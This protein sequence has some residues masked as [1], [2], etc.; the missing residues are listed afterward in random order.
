MCSRLKIRITYSAAQTVITAWAKTLVDSFNTL[1]GLESPIQTLLLFFGLLTLASQP[2]RTP[3]KSPNRSPQIL[4]IEYLT[5]TRLR[6]GKY[7]D[8]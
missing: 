4:S 2:A 8:K 7:H 5:I 1:Q 6:L 3:S